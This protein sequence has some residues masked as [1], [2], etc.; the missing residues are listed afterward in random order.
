MSAIGSYKSNKSGIGIIGEYKKM[1][2]LRMALEGF[3]YLILGFVFTAIL[4]IMIS[5]FKVGMIPGIIIC[6][7]YIP[8]CFLSMIDRIRKIRHKEI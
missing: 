8:I 5:L 1:P 4:F 2:L 6:L 7:A 3:L